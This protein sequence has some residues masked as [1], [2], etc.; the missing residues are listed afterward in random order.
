MVYTA[1]WILH[2]LGELARTA[3]DKPKSVNGVVALRTR[4]HPP[5]TPWAVVPR[6]VRCELVHFR[7]LLGERWDDFSPKEG[8]PVE[9]FK[10]LMRAKPGGAYGWGQGARGVRCEMRGEG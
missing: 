2:E 1:Y 10:K 4:A 5:H 9:P 7:S 6:E 3:P 8:V